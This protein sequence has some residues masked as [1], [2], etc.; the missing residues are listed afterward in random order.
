MKWYRRL[1]VTIPI[2]V[3]LLS[4]GP[5]IVFG[6]NTARQVERALMQDIHQSNHIAIRYAIMQIEIIVKHTLESMSMAATTLDL[7]NVDELDAQYALQLIQKE[8]P[9]LQTVALLDKSGNE[10]AKL[11]LDAIYH[12]SDLISR[13]QEPEFIQALKNHP[14]A[15]QVK[16]SE[17][18]TRRLTLAI[19]LI[20]P[21]D[22]SVSGVLTAEASIRNILEEMPTEN[23]GRGGFIYVVDPAGKIIAHP[24]LSRVLSGQS[25][26][27]NQHFQHFLEGEKEHLEELHR[28]LGPDGGDV[29]SM[30]IE[31]QKLGW[32]FMVEQPAAEA[33]APVN[34]LNRELKMSLAILVPLA[35]AGALYLV[36]G[37]SR[38]LGK[39]QTAAVGLASGHL[40]QQVDIDSGNEIGLV[41]RE[42][43]SM[44]ENLSRT[45]QEQRRM[46]WLKT[47]QVE[48][49]NHIRG[50]QTM[51]AL[52]RSIITFLTK[53][54]DAR[55]GT[56]YVRENDD[57]LRLKAGYAHQ[58]CRSEADIFKLGEGLVGQ[59]ALDGKP[60]L[61]E[62]VPEDYIQVSSGLGE[63][64]P[65]SLIVSP[66]IHEGV[67]AGVMELGFFEAVS[68]TKRDFLNDVSERIAI[69]LISIHE[70]ERL[71]ETLQVSQ[72]QAEELEVQQE[73][74][75]AANEELEEL[76][77]ALQ[78]R[79]TDS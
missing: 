9:Q 71:Q 49:D 57:T 50:N 37:F 54:L 8:I 40:D 17:T 78:A 52:T 62:N 46:D 41:A 24:D 20:D 5:L 42:F 22:R 12:S 61:L 67:A 70:R 19:P 73:E 77:R 29:L 68:D 21:R 1:G 11:S 26:A 48:L 18:G 6:V 53:H 45:A 7:N 64:N 66:F 36:F 43:N 31:S 35:I 69:A 59:A 51:Q 55:V 28:H 79:R 15:G 16:T 56:L 3:L 60:I 13:A 25:I 30:G 47:G 38:P 75:R 34:T 44:A 58:G 72:R 23:V 39:L 74:L 65:A 76:T 32:I 2:I 33:L 27:G 63:T 14:Y 4:L 10:T